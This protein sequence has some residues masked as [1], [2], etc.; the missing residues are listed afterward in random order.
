MTT[1]A[2]FR[3]QYPQYGDRSDADLA[4]ALHKKFYPDMASEDFNRLIGY[5]PVQSQGGPLGAIG[6]GLAAGTEGLLALPG[7]V[8]NIVTAGVGKAAELAGAPPE[9]VAGIDRFRRSIPL[10]TPAQV[11][12]TVQG[13]TGYKPLTDEQ[14]KALPQMEKYLYHGSEM[15]PGAAAFGAA[16]G[17]VAALKTAAKYGVIPGMGGEA[18]V[19]ATNAEGSPDE[20]WIRTLG[21]IGTGLGVGGIG[22]MGKWA[23]LPKEPNIQAIATKGRH[24]EA[25][26]SRAYDMVD[27][28]GIKI[29]P[30]SLQALNSRIVTVLASKGFDVANLPAETKRALGMI[31]SLANE[32][33]SFTYLDNVR[34][35][36]R[37]AFNTSEPTT[38]MLAG[39]MT[40]QM[41]D[42][43]ANL[44]GADI[45]GGAAPRAAQQALL[46]ARDLW[47]RS[48]RFQNKAEII[49][50]IWESALDKVGANYTKA[51]IQTAVRQ[52]FR[53][54]NDKLR[55]DPDLARQFTATERLA[56]NDV[57]RGG[58]M[59]N[60]LRKIGSF[61]PVSPS[62]AAFSGASTGPIGAGIG[63]LMS[64][65]PEGAALGTLAGPL[66][67]A[68]IGGPA[69]AAS[70]VAQRRMIDALI[71]NVL[72]EGR[73]FKMPPTTAFNPAM[74]IPY[75]QA[76]RAAPTAAE[77]AQALSAPSAQPAR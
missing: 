35:N 2:E 60:V 18:V 51:G 27:Q 17:P 40:R 73:P 20:W 39:L 29:D 48:A 10:A 64:G 57:V 71:G 49:G 8:A 50:N 21:S 63:Y 9:T 69:R 30:L 14:V 28:S 46:Q 11:A 38:R 62:A 12:N 15:V 25:A 52:G 75:I 16:Y 43:I 5:R 58:P 47:G 56:I 26:A 76:S 13:V 24:L 33:R 74:A 77:M 54:L 59:E 67:G 3:A 42:Y 34:K 72:N 31:G 61:A 22:A 55:K 66:A 32:P 6:H 41:D 4:D 19:Q 44:G 36:V 1:L 23:T 37:D 65:T 45:I 53:S 7:G 70:N 68:L